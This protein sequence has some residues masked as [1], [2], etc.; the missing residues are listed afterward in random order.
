MKNY[1]IFVLFIFLFYIVLVLILSKKFFIFVGEFNIYIREVGVGGLFI[2]V[3]GFFKVE[4]DFD[5]RK[6]GSC[7]V[8][9]VVIEFG[10]YLVFVKFNDEYI[11]EFFFKVYI[12]FSI[13]DVR[14]LFVVVF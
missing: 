7:G 5:D 11:L 2:V 1:E 3:E 6:D 12:I 10:E 13:G 14:K 9:Y 4:L 8:K